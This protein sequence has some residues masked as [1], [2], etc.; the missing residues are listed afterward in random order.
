MITTIGVAR[1]P[2]VVFVTASDQYALRAFEVH[3]LDYLITPF[4]DERFREALDRA[5]RQVRQGR[6]SE[7]GHRL[8]DLLDGNGAGHAGGGGGAGAAARRFVIKSGGRVTLLP[9]RDVDWI[10]AA[11]DYA[12]LHAGKLSPVVRD[13][14]KGLEAQLDPTRFIRI[15]RSTI[16]N[17]ERVKELQPMFKGEYVIVLFDGT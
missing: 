10:E 3:A 9:V 4:S 5:K 2:A 7:L 15:H 6:V 17:I 12:R 11:G 1:M 16:V 14:M 13:T 8:A